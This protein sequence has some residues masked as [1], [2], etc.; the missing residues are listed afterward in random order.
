MAY[1]VIESEPGLWTVGIYH[2][3]KGRTPASWESVR[4]FEERVQ[5]YNF[6]AWI[7]AGRPLPEF[8]EITRPKEPVEEYNYTDP[9]HYRRYP[10]EVI[11]QMERVFGTKALVIFCQLNAFKYRSRMG[12]KPGQPFERDLEKEDWYLTKAEE[13]R[14]KLSTGKAIEP[15]PGINLFY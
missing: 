7:N 8:N 14:L 3:E 13:L 1:E 12:T 11:D 9:N 10:V 6:A 5:A 15:D 4:D 2:D